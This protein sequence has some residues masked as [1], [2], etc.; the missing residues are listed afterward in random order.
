MFHV[1]KNLQTERL[2]RNSILHQSGGLY[3]FSSSSL[4]CFL[5]FLVILQDHSAVLGGVGPVFGAQLRAVCNLDRGNF[6]SFCRPA[7]FRYGAKAVC[8]A[9]LRV[10]V[11][12]NLVA[13][14]IV[15][16][17]VDTDELTLG[18]A[19]GAFTVPVE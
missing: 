4:Y 19:F 2:L 3:A 10:V 14:L 15:S 11:V 7:F 16:F 12:V 5:F 18:R 9:G 8:F 1:R 17:A 6:R 13:C